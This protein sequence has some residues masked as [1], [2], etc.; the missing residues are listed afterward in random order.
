VLPVLETLDSVDEVRAIAEDPEQYLKELEAEGRLQPI[1][2]LSRSLQ[3][4]LYLDISRMIVFSFH[5]AVTVADN[6]SLWGHR[7]Q[8]TQTP[9]FGEKTRARER[10]VGEAQLRIIVDAMVA[11]QVVKTPMVLKPLEKRLFTNC[12]MVVFQLI[13]ELLA[14]EGEEVTFLGHKLRFILEPEPAELVRRLLEEQPVTHCQINEAAVAE[15]VEELLADQDTNIQWLPD[16]IESQI[17]QG[18]MRLMI[19][20]A[21]HVVCRLRL[22][23]LGREIHMS[24]LS[25]G[26][27]RA[28][29]E[30]LASQQTKEAVLYFEEEDPL[31]TVSTTELEERL[32][33]LSEQRRVLQARQASAARKRCSRG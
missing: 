11:S 12:M 25:S 23:F 16:V 20:I 26:D 30:R 17:Y 1:P 3:H 27:L 31:R 29:R 8:V 5:R 22:N 10:C 2:L 14:G 13:N 6:A 15:L 28:P 7:L 18:V 19:R 21:E 32:K 24:I 9:I 4:K 33:D